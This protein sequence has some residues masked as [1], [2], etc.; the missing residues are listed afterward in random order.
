LP[1]AH[2]VLRDPFQ[3]IQAAKTHRCVGVVEL[4]DGFALQV[5]DAAFGC[6]EFYVHLSMLGVLLTAGTEE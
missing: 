1:L 2:V 4:F 3:G 5:G 6:V